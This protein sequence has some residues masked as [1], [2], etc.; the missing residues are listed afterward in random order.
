VWYLSYPNLSQYYVRVR[1]RTAVEKFSNLVNLWE[2]SKARIG[3][4]R[5]DEMAL[6]AMKGHVSELVACQWDDEEQAFE[7]IDTLTSTFALFHDNT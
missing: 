5:V 6:H 7:E 3:D 1:D 2:C 4:V